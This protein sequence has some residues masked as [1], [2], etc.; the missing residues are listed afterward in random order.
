MPFFVNKSSEI[1]N[2]LSGKNSLQSSLVE[3]HGF[4]SLLFIVSSRHRQDA[5]SGSHD[6]HKSVLRMLAKKKY[7]AT[8]MMTL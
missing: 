3:F 7:V 6:V 1:V 4:G 5:H 2:I 8:A